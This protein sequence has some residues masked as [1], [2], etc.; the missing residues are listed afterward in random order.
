MNIIYLCFYSFENLNNEIIRLLENGFQKLYK[1]IAMMLNI[2][3]T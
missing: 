2:L 1:F 3:K